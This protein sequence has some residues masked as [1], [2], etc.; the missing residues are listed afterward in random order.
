MHDFLIEHFFA[1]DNWTYLQ[2]IYVAFCLSVLVDA[3]GKFDFH[4]TT[5][6]FFS[7]GKHEVYNLSKRE[8]F[9]LQHV[10]ECNHAASVA[11]FA[12]ANH[13]VVGVESRHHIA[14]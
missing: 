7:F 8:C 5:H 9:V 2:P 12:V 14:Q 6:L 10:G 11:V 13:L 3:S 4:R 1:V